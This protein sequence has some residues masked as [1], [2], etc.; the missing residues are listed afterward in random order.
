M[1]KQK[2]DIT[3]PFF[4]IYILII[5]LFISCDILHIA[6]KEK[7]DSK[8]NRKTE[9]NNTKN[10]DTDNDNSNINSNQQDTMFPPDRWTLAV[11]H[12]Q[13]DPWWIELEFKYTPDLSAIVQ[14]VIDRDGWTPGN[15]LTFIF[16]G[17]S[18]RT[19][20]SFDGTGDTVIYRP[21][22]IIEYSV[23]KLF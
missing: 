15:A 4:F 17:T 20:K 1:K 8:N 22:L 5:F 13:P 7:H 14:E 6:I 16:S 3:V 19:V 2:I 18:K 11:I 10:P 23:L 21:S 12:L 9:K